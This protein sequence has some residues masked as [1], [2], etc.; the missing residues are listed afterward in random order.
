MR[1]QEGTNREDRDPLISGLESR[2]EVT[3][4]RIASGGSLGAEAT[5]RWM[6]GKAEHLYK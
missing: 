5:R 1:V 3:D 4:Q 2:L 6:A